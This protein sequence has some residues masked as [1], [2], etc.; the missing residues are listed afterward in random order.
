MKRKGWG[1]IE[2][3]IH[4]LNLVTDMSVLDADTRPQSSGLET[5]RAAAKN[6]CSF[7]EDL[8]GLMPV[9]DLW[10]LSREDDASQVYEW[11]I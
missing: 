7:S 9:Y 8:L 1:L 4:A 6:P 10:L 3:V 11:V 2:T 5:V